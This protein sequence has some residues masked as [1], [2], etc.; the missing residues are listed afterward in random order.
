[1]WR[2]LCIGLISLHLLLFIAIAGWFFSLPRS[3]ATPSIPAMS[4]VRTTSAG[5]EVQIGEDASNA[6]LAQA[7]ADQPDVQRILANAAVHFGETWNAD[8]GIKVDQRVVPF[9]ISFLPSVSNGDLNLQIVDATMGSTTMTD[10]LVN[11]IQLLPLPDWITFS[12]ATE[13]LHLH[14]AALPTKQVE[15]EP[16]GYS[17]RNHELTILVTPTLS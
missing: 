3:S 6:F 10:T 14:F 12:P 16:I 13:T 1:M 15:I 2:R 11:I 17:A 7:L 5:V 4:V 8:V 9:Q